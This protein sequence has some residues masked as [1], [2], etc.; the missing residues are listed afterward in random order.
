LEVTSRPLD[1]YSC[2]ADR[3]IAADGVPTLRQHCG[4]RVVIG[5]WRR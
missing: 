3:A 5:A 2:I 4:N 1:A